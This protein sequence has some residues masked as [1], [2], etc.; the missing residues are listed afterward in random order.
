MVDCKN[1][2]HGKILFVQERNRETK[3]M[4]HIPYKRVA[5]SSPKYNGRT[6]LVN[7]IRESCPYFQK[8]ERKST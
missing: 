2:K 3:V 1:C 6:F 5:C 8:R 4:Q 7:C